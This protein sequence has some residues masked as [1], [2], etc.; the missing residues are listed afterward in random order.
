VTL[1]SKR[2]GKKTGAVVS[3]V[4]EHRKER[5]KNKRCIKKRYAVVQYNKFTKGVG[6]AD[7]YLSYYSVL[8]K[9]VKWSKK[10]VLYLLNCALLSA[11]CV[12]N[13]KHTQKIKCESFLHRVE[14]SWV[15]K[16]RNTTEPSSDELQWP[17]RQPA[18]RGHKQGP[19]ADCSGIS[20][21]TNWT[22]LLLV[23][24]A[25]RSVLQDSVKDVRNI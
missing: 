11:F 19:S 1:W 14:R 7:Q 3:T 15:S 18:P 23:G 24:R 5:Q 21:N 12:Q 16:V 6:R 4:G 9:T 20:A 13:T 10:L 17:D 2:E 22:K 25:R 8:R